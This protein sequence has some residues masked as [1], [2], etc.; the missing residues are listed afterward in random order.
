M[1]QLIRSR[2]RNRLS[3]YW[4]QRPDHVPVYFRVLVVRV[5]MHHLAADG[6]VHVRRLVVQRRVWRKAHKPSTH[7]L[8]I[9]RG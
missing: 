5:L 1:S 6:A 7:R 9:K 8:H 2:Y 4:T 3:S